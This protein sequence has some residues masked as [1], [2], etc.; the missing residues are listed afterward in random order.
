MG[1]ERY[2]TVEE[3]NSTLPLVKRIVADIVADYEGWRERVRKFELISG[4]VTSAEGE[5]PEQAALRQ[6]VDEAARRISGYVE[7]LSQIGCVLKGFDDGLVDF[8]SKREGR[9]VF[10]CW[11]L[12]EDAVEHWHEIDAGFAGR[13]PLVPETVAGDSEK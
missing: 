11:K 3:A 8:Y 10:L 9:D 2:F 1:D 5:T 12:G 4:G 13:M 7:E 6:E